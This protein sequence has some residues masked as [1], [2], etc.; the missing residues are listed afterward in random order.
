MELGFTSLGRLVFA[1]DS[2][3][4]SQGLRFRSSNKM[5]LAVNAALKATV[6]HDGQKTEEQAEELLVRMERDGRLLEECWS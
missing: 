5:P 2:L 4:D 3:G 1:M 6:C